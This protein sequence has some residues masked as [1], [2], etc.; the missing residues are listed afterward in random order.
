LKRGIIDYMGKYPVYLELK[1]R[2]VVIIGAGAVALRKAKTL[3]EA[4][5]R[6][7]I[8]DE[9]IDDMLA[10]LC[11]NA[12]AELIRSR[13]SKEYLLGA[14]LVIAATNDEKINKQIYKDCQELEIL[15]NVVDQPQA[16][17]FFGPATVRRGNLQIAV[18]TNGNCPAYAGHI[19]KKLEKI[20]TEKH[21]QFLD[22]L[23]IFRTQMFEQICDPAQRKTILGKLVADESFDYFLENGPSAWQSYAGKIIT[24]Y[25]NKL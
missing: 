17:D 18:A 4:K 22:E 20:F 6:L 16:C 9:K 23:Q 24:E 12:N 14:V 1:D 11:R 10:A 3:L 15:C 25:R 21:G 19:K 5:A 8:V 7:V 13:Y 2:R